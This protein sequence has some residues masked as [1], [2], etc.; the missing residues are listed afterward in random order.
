MDK[1]K[2]KKLTIEEKLMGSNKDLHKQ[3]KNINK[4]TPNRSLKETR[5]RLYI[6]RRCLVMLLCWREPRD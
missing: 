3:V 6:I 4:L 2:V 1:C 5:S